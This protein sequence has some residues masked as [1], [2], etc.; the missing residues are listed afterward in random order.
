MSFAVKL[1]DLLIPILVYVLF[2]TNAFFNL[3]KKMF[4]T[5]LPKINYEKARIKNIKQYKDS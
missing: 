4:L 3:Q 2:L 5:N 1:K